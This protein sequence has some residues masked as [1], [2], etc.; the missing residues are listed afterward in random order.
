M[1][2]NK[3]LGKW[4]YEVGE[5]VNIISYPSRRRNLPIVWVPE[6]TQFCGQT[7]TISFVDEFD[8]T[9]KTEESGWFWWCNEFFEKD[10]FLNE[11]DKDDAEFSIDTHDFLSSFIVR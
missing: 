1:K 2:Y 4:L 8:G 5:R 7:V 11:E 3:R 9:Y 10:Y 6:M